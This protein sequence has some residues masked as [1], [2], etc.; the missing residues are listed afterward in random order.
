MVGVSSGRIEATP[1]TILLLAAALAAAPAAAEPAPPAPLEFANR[2]IVTLRATTHGIIPE[3]RVAG[4]QGRLREI[5]SEPPNG[6]VEAKAIDEGYLITIGGVGAFRLLTEDVDP[7]GDDT[8]ETLRDRTV[9]NLRTAW[10]RSRRRGAFR[11][12][13]ARW[14]SRR[15]PRSRSPCSS[16]S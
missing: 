2:P 16:S 10:R 6:E 4:I 5:V 13:C 11:A 9:A 7:L 8:L 1:L 3:S 12:S 15:S 14:A